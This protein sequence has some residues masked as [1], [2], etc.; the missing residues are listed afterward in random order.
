MVVIDIDDA[1]YGKRNFIRFSGTVICRI[2]Y[3]NRVI[4]VSY[5]LVTC[6]ALDTRL[7]PDTVMVGLA[8]E[9]PKASVDLADCAEATRGRFMGK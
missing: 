7:L 9:E 6:V 1:G 4:A 5:R 3:H 2:G 8:G